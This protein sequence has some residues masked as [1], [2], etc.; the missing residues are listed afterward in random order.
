MLCY[1]YF[2]DWCAWKD[3][4]AC[5][6]CVRPYHVFSNLQL[7]SGIICVRYGVLF[8]LWWWLIV[9]RGRCVTVNNSGIIVSFITEESVYVDGDYM[10]GVQRVLAR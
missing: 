5:R 4:V 9:V 2:C 1:L 8:R 3:E 10:G 6:A 7:C